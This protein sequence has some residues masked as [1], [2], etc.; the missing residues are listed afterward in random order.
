LIVTHLLSRAA[1]SLSLFLALTL[2]AGHLRAESLAG[3]Y[4]AAVQASYNNEYEKAAFYYT[5]ALAR[6]PD[7]PDLMQNALLAFLSKGDVKQARAIARR[8]EAINADSQLSQLV[9]MTDLLREG[10][11]AAAKGLFASGVEFSPLLDGLMQGW[12]YLGLGQMS[13]AVARFEAMGTSPAMQAF[14]DYHRAMAL[15]VVGDFESAERLLAGDT[16]PIRIGRGSLIAHITILSQLDRN[17]EAMEIVDMA[18]NG[19]AD[20]EIVALRARLVNG[21]TLPFTHIT[22]ATEG[23]SEVFMSLATVLAGDENDRF[24][25]IYGRMAE[26]L[27]PDSTAALLLVAEQLNEQGQY[28]L[29]VENYNRVPADSPVFFSA[30]IGRAESL[31]ADGKA[32]AAIE[33]LRGLTKTHGQIPSV[34]TSLGDA[35]RRESRFAEAT[36]A[37][38]A[39][40]DLM[41]EPLPNHWFLYYA[42]GI[43]YEREGAWDQAEADFRFALELSPDQPLVLN[44]L[45]Y[46]LVEKRIKMTEAQ[47]MIETA[48]ARRPN[49]GYITDSLGWV[50]YRLDKFAE[51]V[52]HLERAVE[53]LPVDP[54]IND[55]LGDAYWK[56]G[57][58]LEAQFQW[59]RALSFE[60][61]EKDATRIRKKLE[62]GLDVVLDDEAKTVASE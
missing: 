14:S 37:Y 50:L 51:A 46:G 58:K 16:T 20:P 59:R 26:Y 34:Q 44:Y 3:A 52:P 21:E 2:G 6:D 54:I 24:G 17:N 47:G 18:L 15:A 10:D 32:E 42:R 53:L 57:R 29:A 11:F 7:N 25:L 19:S 40:I 22:N 60:P 28:A 9:T 38:S 55:H 56:V 30:E 61:E 48:V 1:L 45:G 5:K 35:L 62:L 8:M 33:V 49:D 12:I 36:L 13:E 27:R 41:S 43:T 39:A 4:L 23:A 31:I